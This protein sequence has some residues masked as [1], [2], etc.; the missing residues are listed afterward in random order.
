[1]FFEW[2]GCR[3]NGVG[4]EIRLKRQNVLLGTKKR[5]KKWRSGGKW[6]LTYCNKVK[7]GKWSFQ[8]CTVINN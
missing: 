1:M 7:G 6:E 5:G 4:M 3:W 2:N 8:A